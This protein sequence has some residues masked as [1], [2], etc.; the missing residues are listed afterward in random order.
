MIKYLE[1]HY[2]SDFY[3]YM[4]GDIIM[5]SQIYDVLVTLL[6]MRKNQTISDQ[7]LVSIIDVI[8]RYMWLEGEY[9]FSL[10]NIIWFEDIWSIMTSL[11]IMLVKILNLMDAIQWYFNNWN[12]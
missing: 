4:N 11:Q 3:G 12:W 8:V 6:E 7:V 9:R 2:V 5:S 10:M 1:S